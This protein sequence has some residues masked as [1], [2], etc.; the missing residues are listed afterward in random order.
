[1]LTF[2]AE[3]I[4][5]WH[6]T[7]INMK[8]EVFKLKTQSEL[9]QQDEISMH[10][11]DC[12]IDTQ[13]RDLILKV[14]ACTFLVSM[15]FLRITNNVVDPD[16][17]HQMALIR[18]FI[19]LG[20]IPLEDRFAY[21]PT[22][23]PSVHHEWGAGAIAYFLATR[24]GAPGI[25]TAKYLLALIILAFSFLCLRRRSAGI[26]VLLFLAP[27]GIL[28]IDRGF[29]TIRGQMYSLAFLAC[30]L[31]FLDLDRNGT[32]SWIIA[33]IPLFVIWINLHAG[34][35]VGIGL[36]GAFWLERLLQRKPHTHLILTILLM[37][38][39]IALNPYGF[40]YY[41][42]LWRAMTM[43][44]PHIEEWYPIW[45]GLDLLHLSAFIVSLILLAYSVKEIG[46]RNCQ[47]IALI[48][49]T[50][51]A[52][53]FCN[54]LVL[55]YAILW[56]CYV[57]GYLRITPLGNIICG[58]CKKRS[59]FLILLLCLATVVFFARTLSFRPWKLLVPNDYIKGYDKNMIYP[60]GP[61]DY[62]S[63]I[64]F[65]GNLMVDFD[66]GAYVSWKLHPDVCVSMDSRYEAAYPEW[67]VGENFQFYTAKEDWQRIL[68]AYPTDLVLVDKRLPLAKVMPQSGWKKIYTDKG[69][70]IYARPCLTMPV[71]D[72]TGR[73]FKGVFP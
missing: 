11:Q 71:V 15:Y 3:L 6:N 54:R 46:I 55:F 45:R 59:R 14:V 66:C 5:L 26:E 25:L 38:V 70:E 51:L 19:T 61:V 39:L 4:K 44:R 12:G 32:R 53:I 16:L 42:Y 27:I 56:T 34:F 28:L 40:K 58:L 20:H 64:A 49:T 22:I 57:P 63:E 60:I 1:M 50:S 30:L 18:E 9:M 33:W 43:A 7:L 24:F 37:A 67:L 21:T 68:T 73:S 36:L 47:G 72:W 10:L 2:Q 35:L 41:P 52:S 69:F 17:W 29:S 31:W 62:L 48:M 13:K 65:K 23:Y 8:K